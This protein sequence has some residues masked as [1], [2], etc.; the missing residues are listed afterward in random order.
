MTRPSKREVERQLDE[1]VPDSRSGPSKIELK[2]TVIGTGWDLSDT[3]N[4]YT[5][6]DPD[7]TKTETVEVEL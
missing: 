5:D 2:D 3:S 1:L 4:G 7:E 6:L